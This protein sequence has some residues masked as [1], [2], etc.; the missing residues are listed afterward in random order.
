MYIRKIEDTMKLLEQTVAA[1]TE[2]EKLQ[3][4]WYAFKTGDDE[5]TQK[6]AQELSEDGCDKECIFQKYFAI[7]D[8]EPSWVEQIELLLVSLEMLRLKEKQ[9]LELLTQVVKAYQKENSEK[10]KE[11][12]VSVEEKAASAE[13]V[14]ASAEQEV[15]ETIAQKKVL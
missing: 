6:L 8:R 7:A 10:E 15:A 1:F 13:P 3:I 14:E 4:L 2:T 12:A 11:A 5:L 9:A